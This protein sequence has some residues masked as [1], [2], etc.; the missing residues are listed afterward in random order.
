MLKPYY[1]DF[2]LSSSPHQVQIIGLNLVFLLTKGLLK[3]F[4][5]ELE[6]IPSLLNN[7]YIKFS[8]ELER[9]MNEGRYNRVW[10]AIKHMPDE[11]YAFFIEKIIN[12]ARVD[13]S[14]CM[15]VAY[16][17]LA[18]KDAMEL[19]HFLPNETVSFLEFSSKNGRNWTIE[20]DKIVNFKDDDNE[21]SS[22]NT[23]ALNL[24]HKSLSYAHEIERI[25]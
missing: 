6:L 13:I 11:S 15:E 12:A 8:I 21:N 18:V 9:D 25:I 20:N 7:P 1:F 3:N 14:K 5:T 23:S 4:H 10:N 22:F 2:G 19:L 24:V 17:D 16:T